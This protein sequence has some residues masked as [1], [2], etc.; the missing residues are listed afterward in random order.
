MIGALHKCYVGLCDVLSML[1]RLRIRLPLKNCI[2][3][4]ALDTARSYFKVVTHFD[5]SIFDKSNV[6]VFCDQSTT[7]LLEQSSIEGLTLYS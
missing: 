1:M 7:K 2:Q 3:R 6:K 5:R 4:L